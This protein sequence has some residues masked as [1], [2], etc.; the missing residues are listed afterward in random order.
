MHGPVLH[1]LGLCQRAGKAVSG[2][3][4]VR[5]NISKGKVKAMIIATDTSEKVKQEYI[6]L[7]K[8]NKI[9]TVLVLTKQEI[10]LALGKSARVAVAI[11]DSNFA[12]GIS[13]LL[14]RS[15]V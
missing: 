1:L 7:G 14:D 13:R 6:Q 2:D 4:A 11:L 5:A 15:E 12:Q 9:P 3:F 8:T 10:G